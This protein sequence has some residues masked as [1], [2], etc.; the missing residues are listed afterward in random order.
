MVTQRVDCNHSLSV[1]TQVELQHEIK[2][3]S[4]VAA[5]LSGFKIITIA[6][7]LFKNSEIIFSQCDSYI[8]SV[9]LFQSG[10]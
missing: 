8:G 9:F 2:Y 5:I 1:Q 6:L 7:H 3:T 10:F 4:T